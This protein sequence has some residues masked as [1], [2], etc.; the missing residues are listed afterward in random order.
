MQFVDANGVP[1]GAAES[2]SSF[3]VHMGSNKDT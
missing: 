1:Q 3:G 2:L